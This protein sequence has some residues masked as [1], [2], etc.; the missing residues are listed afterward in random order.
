MFR[1]LGAVALFGLLG[2]AGPAHAQPYHFEDTLRGSTMGN[3]EGGS[4]GA[5]GWTVTAVDDRIWYALPR[6]ASGS[7]ELTVANITPANLPLADHEIVAMYEAGYG[8]A[9]PIRYNPE[10]R[11]N[12]YK[13]LVRIYGTAE[14]GRT[15]AMKLMWGMCPS[16]APGYDACGCGSYF[17]EPFAD[18]G[19]W[20]GAPVR[21]RIEWDGT[22]ARLLRDGALVTSVDWGTGLTFGPSEPH[23]SL[24]SP[25]NDG[26]LSAMPIGAVFSDLVIDGMRGPLATCPGSTDAGPGVDGGP[27]P[28]A[29]GCNGDA[30]LADATAASWEPGVYP[31]ATDLNVEGNGTAPTGVVY[32]RMPAVPSAF[33]RATLT[34]HTAVGGSSGGGSGIV[35]RVDGAWDE[36]S[37]TWASRPSVSTDCVGTARTVGAN[38]EVAFDITPL[39]TAG[40]AISL[41][42]VSTDTDGVHYVSRE[43]GGC[44]SGPRLTYVLSEGDA[45]GTDAGSRD[46]A[47]SSD[48]GAAMD[49]GLGPRGSGGCACS[50]GRGGASLGGILLGLLAAALVARR[51]R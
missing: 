43:A 10:F 51:A 50:A 28:D 29:G 37:L 36:A 8:I 44:I 33:R 38:E 32:L 4:F 17:E 48:G 15:G 21:I 16:G 49:G 40:A 46:A 34:L 3:A 9:E 26:G 47:V 18:P 14:P 22:S 30:A 39:V 13:M 25:R 7:I 12:H 45:A 6:L 35:C 11:N 20:T 1:F 31:D 23:F 24:G 2:L 19:A 27:L 41:A 5:S 42:V